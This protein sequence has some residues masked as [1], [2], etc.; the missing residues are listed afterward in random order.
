[1]YGRLSGLVNFST[2]FGQLCAHHQENLLYLCDTVWSADKQT[3]Q[4]RIDTIS[5][6]DDGHIVAR[7]M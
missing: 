1:V 6:P 3:R 4:C 7:N 5:S 2:C